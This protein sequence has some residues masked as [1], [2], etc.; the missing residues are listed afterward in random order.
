MI[1]TDRDYLNIISIDKEREIGFDEIEEILSS[2]PLNIIYVEKNGLLHGIISTGDI[3]RSKKE[4][5]KTVRINTEYHRLISDSYVDYMSFFRNK[6]NISSLPLLKSEGELV[7]EIQLGEGIFYMLD[8]FDFLLWD[9][10]NEVINEV[11]P[12]YLIK[13]NEKFNRKSGCYDNW[14]NALSNHG[15]D[16]R[17]I[18][19]SEI[20][21]N[22]DANSSVLFIDEDEMK[23]TL[24]LYESIRGV[25]AIKCHVMTISEFRKLIIERVIRNNGEKLVDSICGDFFCKLKNGGV[26]VFAIQIIDEECG[27][28]DDLNNRIENKYL[29]ENT[30]KTC[31]ILKKWEEIFFEELYSE[32][33]VKKIT[34]HLFPMEKIDGVSILKDYESEYYN[35]NNHMRRTTNQPYNYIQ[36]IYFFGP[37]IAVGQFVEDGYTIESCLQRRLNV[38][39]YRVKVINKGSWYYDLQELSLISKTEFNIGDIVIVYLSNRTIDGIK[40]INL[41]QV[42]QKN[43]ISEGWFVDMP[44][45]GNHKVYELFADEIFAH[46]RKDLIEE[47]KE[48]VCNIVPVDDPMIYNY[49]SMLKRKI[50]VRSFSKIGSI[51]MNCNPFTLGHRYLVEQALEYVDCLIIFVVE[52]DKSVFPFDMRFAA[53]KQGLRDIENVFVVPSGQF[54]LSWNTFPEYFMKVSDDDIHNNIEYDLIVFAK[55]IAPS[56]N[57]KY[58]FVGEEIDDAVTR[59][60]NVAMQRILPSYGIEIVEIPRKKIKDRAISASLVRRELS[61]GDR[62]SCK[63]YI[64]DATHDILYW[65]NN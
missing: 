2:N 9:G 12:L 51:V 59:E 16:V 10:V 8:D 44:E 17:K 28:L 7:G 20:I 58:R 3:R 65:D 21:E 14:Y 47:K 62:N 22:L 37:C 48:L 53:I 24:T 25:D 29:A 64:P 15:F 31:K 1:Y 50:D 60:Y 45:H 26:N 18:D 43:D 27:F 42:L 52:E 30:N 5:E 4:G 33:Y 35:V 23:G 11:Q 6:T 13:P 41:E 54:I 19:R 38:E 32:D 56:M 34:N 49:I 63:I 57:I 36:E 39:G 55:Q 46:I 61:I 40:N